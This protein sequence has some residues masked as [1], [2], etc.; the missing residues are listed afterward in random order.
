MKRAH[1]SMLL[2]ISMFRNHIWYKT[3]SIELHHSCHD[4]FVVSFGFPLTIWSNQTNWT[5]VNKKNDHRCRHPERL[6]VNDH[7]L[8][9]THT[10]SDVCLISNYQYLNT[11]LRI[12][13]LSTAQPISISTFCEENCVMNFTRTP[14]KI[15]RLKSQKPASTSKINH[16]RSTHCKTHPTV[17]FVSWLS[18]LFTA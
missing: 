9:L 16:E 3:N 15:T 2:F 6:S 13:I 12:R 18:I 7:H 4:M 14:L 8:T 1:Q 11:P 17:Q 10:D 5:C